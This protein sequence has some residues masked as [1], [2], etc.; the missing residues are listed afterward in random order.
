MSPLIE[1]TFVLISVLDSS[2][3]ICVDLW[4]NLSSISVAGR[5]VQRGCRG[6]IY[7][8]LFQ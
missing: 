8:H 4:L 5:R 3:L 2:V 1:P 6:R 7:R